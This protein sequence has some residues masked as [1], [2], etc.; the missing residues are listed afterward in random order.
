MTESAPLKDVSWGKMQGLKSGEAMRSIS[1][2][3]RAL[4]AVGST[5]YTPQASQR[6]LLA[7]ARPHR[8][9]N[10]AHTVAST[11]TAIEILNDTA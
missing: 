3:G 11:S 7:C 8:P 5:H 10:H 2:P 6:D 1:R 4:D 9:A